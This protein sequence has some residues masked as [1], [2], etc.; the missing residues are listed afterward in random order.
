[1]MRAATSA[2]RRDIQVA[3]LLLAPT[4]LLL[5]TVLAYP[6]GWEVWTSLTD[7]SPLKS[8]APAFVGLENY[9][10]LI[11]DSE[12]WRAATVTVVYDAVT[13]VAKLS[14]GVGFALLLARPFRGRA[15]IFLAV[16]MPWAYPASV[17]VIGWY[18]TLNPPIPTAYSVFMGNVKYAVD[19]GLGGGAWAFVSVT[20]FNIWRGSS[21][22][23]VFLLAG[24]N[25][26]PPELFEC[27]VL[28]S[29][30]AWRRFWL[31]TVPLLK[32]FLALAVFLTMTTAFADLANVWMLTGGRIVYP[33]IGTHAYWLAI[34]GGQFGPACALSLTLVPFLLAVLLVLFKMFDPPERE[35]A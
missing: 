22:I 8:G 4:V 25:A 2:R 21:F 19:G 20:L 3:Y 30:S 18:W 5:L 29:K 26:V 33:V 24:I 31:V 35:R 1:M 13:S 28:E 27:A 34:R 16:F 9:R 23:G 6:V 32:P 7:L 17:S 15:L 14:L 10:N 11:A 12:F